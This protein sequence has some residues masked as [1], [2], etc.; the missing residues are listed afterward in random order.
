MCICF[1]MFLVYK[2][3]LD[4]DK[5]ILG[6]EIMMKWINVNYLGNM[7]MDVYDNLKVMYVYCD[8]VDF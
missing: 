4:S 3:G 6:D 2:L 5:M 1:F 7:I 8:I